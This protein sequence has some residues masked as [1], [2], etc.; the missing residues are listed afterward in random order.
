MLELIVRRNVGMYL[1]VAREAE[2]MSGF[3]WGSSITRRNC[4]P[5][6][7]LAGNLI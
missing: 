5:S 3:E 4:A 1:L 7:K 6:L 2:I